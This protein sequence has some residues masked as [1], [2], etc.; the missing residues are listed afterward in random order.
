M[1]SSSPNSYALTHGP[2]H[3]P[4]YGPDIDGLRAIAVLCVLGFHVFTNSIK[5][6]FIGVDISFVIPRYLIASDL[7]R[8]TFSFC[9]FYMRR[10]SRIFPVLTR[11]LLASLLIGSFVLLPS[12]LQNLDK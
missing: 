4:G 2:A 10:I 3:P 1:S 8:G 5:G 9:N 12:E 6:G 7:K 11:V